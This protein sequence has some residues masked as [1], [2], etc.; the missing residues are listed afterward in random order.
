MGN[1]TA[2]LGLRFDHYD[3]LDQ[4]ILLEPRLGLSYAVPHSGTILRAS[5]DARSKRPTTK[6]C[7][8]RRAWDRAPR[9]SV[10]DNRPGRAV[11]IRARS[12]FS[13]GSAS[14]SWSMSATSTNT[15]RTVR[16]QRPVRHADRVSRGVGP[17]TD[18]R[19]YRP[20]QPRGAC[21]LQRV[22]GPGPHQRDLLAARR[23]RLLLEAP[24][25]DFRIDHDQKFNSTV[26]VQY[27]LRTK[28]SAPGWHSPG[29][30]TPGWSPVPSGVSTTRST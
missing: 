15:Q 19:L 13:S 3:G 25:G 11:A 22:R 21:G 8:C 9:W 2:K 12:G 17:L 1:V 14:G 7:S 4:R 28:R 18:R 5:S 27:T 29:G 30:T 16:L 26:N 10:T 23:G 24:D 6:T 20:H